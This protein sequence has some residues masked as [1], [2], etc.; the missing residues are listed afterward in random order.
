MK[1]KRIIST[2]IIIILMI[3]FFRIFHYFDETL[4]SDGV[5]NK[6]RFSIPI[7]V[8]VSEN[9]SP[10]IKFCELVKKPEKIVFN[11]Q[12]W[13]E[14]T[15]QSIYLYSAYSD[16]RYQLKDKSYQYIRIIA[17]V[18]N[19]LHSKQL[20]C[21]LWISYSVFPLIV[22]VISN[23]LWVD[24]WSKDLTLP[25]YKTYLLSCPVPQDFKNKVIG[26]SIASHECEK[27]KNFL[28]VKQNYSNKDK[29]DF[30][31]CV[32]GLDFHEDISLRL[33]EWIEL[34]LRLGASLISF[35]IY[36]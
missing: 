28:E 1:L 25:L 16:D 22:S 9:L 31:V 33:I 12:Y 30:A 27:P 17:T 20:Y 23:E 26:V 14:V 18:K 15:N 19:K 35:Y 36:Y 32:K 4:V 5:K 11:N 21:Y 8:G 2:I 3:F 7:I 34:Q 24:F 10:A 13:Q 6:I 29:K